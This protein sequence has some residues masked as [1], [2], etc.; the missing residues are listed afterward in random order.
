MT[1]TLDDGLAWRLVA[2]AADLC[3][4]E[5]FNLSVA[6]VRDDGRSDMRRREERARSLARL[7]LY[8]TSRS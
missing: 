6:V 7:V 3:A 1:R 2:E 5:A 8:L 4:N